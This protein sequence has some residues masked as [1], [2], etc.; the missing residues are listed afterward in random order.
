MGFLSNERSLDVVVRNVGAIAQPKLLR[1][2][3]LKDDI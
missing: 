1:Q 3:D 2:P